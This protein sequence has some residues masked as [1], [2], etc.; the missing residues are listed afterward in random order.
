VE[1]EQ[2]ILTSSGTGNS[3]RRCKGRGN[4]KEG[5]TGT[6]WIKLIHFNSILF[7]TMEIN[8]RWSSISLLFMGLIASLITLSAAFALVMAVLLQCR[9]KPKSRGIF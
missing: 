3:M 8:S 6:L 5:G 1:E 9:P 2:G 7:R 4:G